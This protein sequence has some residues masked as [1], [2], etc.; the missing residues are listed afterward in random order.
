ML[1]R[2]ER[3]AKAIS[4]YWNKPLEK[5]PCYE[6]KN[7]SLS[8]SE[9]Q[10][11]ICIFDIMGY[12][13]N[14][15]NQLVRD[16]GD[17]KTDNILLRLN[18][19][20]GDV[21]DTFAVLNALKNHKAKV[22]VRVESLAASA[23]TVL[24]MAGD[25]IQ[26]YSSSLIMIHNAWTFAAG[27]QYNFQDVADLLSK[28]DNNILDSY[29]N[30]TKTGKRELIE[31]MK[32][33]TWLTAKEAKDK[34]FVDTI[35][36][37]GEPAKASFDLSVFATMPNDNKIVAAAEKDVNNIRNIE[38]LLRDAGLSK[39]K[40]KAVLARGWKAIDSS[41][42]DSEDALNEREKALMDKEAKLNLK[43]SILNL[44]HIIRK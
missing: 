8:D 4:A 32:A 3:N 5:S 30:R 23:G 2:N 29:R 22:T 39:D 12:P 9:E 14:D 16:I 10:A 25:E 1:Y 28:I 31:M 20:G 24:M 43:E 42:D 40:A 11:E 38:R 19:P 34:G 18:T 37:S 13:F 44:T 21:I 26:A 35:L 15:L 41:F 36:E 17:I 6:I 7:R 33:E 27:N